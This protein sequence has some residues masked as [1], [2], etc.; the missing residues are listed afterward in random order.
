MPSGSQRVCED[1]FAPQTLS[2]PRWRR[3]E[4]GG[5]GKGNE[6]S[7]IV[8]NLFSPAK[9]LW[10][11]A[12]APAM[13]SIIT[14]GEADGERIMDASPSIW[15][16]RLDSVLQMKAAGE[17]AAQSDM[18]SPWMPA[19]SRITSQRTERTA[20]AY[21][22]RSEGQRLNRA[23]EL[24]SKLGVDKVKLAEKSIIDTTAQ[25]GHH[26]ADYQFAP[27]T[28]QSARGAVSMRGGMWPTSMEYYEYT[29]PSVPAPSATRR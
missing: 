26:S 1:L 2:Q 4:A 24:A 18:S 15:P 8:T 9:S 5:E 20:A 12:S 27:P 28:G 16:T 25:A 29:D 3:V 21:N 10:V 19:S 14:G 6:L 7:N 11:W 22:I 17:K 23:A 13:S